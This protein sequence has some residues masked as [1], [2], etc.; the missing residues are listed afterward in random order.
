M[1]ENL[2]YREY[3]TSKAWQ[4]K[5]AWYWAKVGK[6]ACQI[7]GNRQG[8]HVHHM[9]YDH[10][11]NEWFTDL[12]GVCYACHDGIHELHRKT[13]G[14][15]YVATMIYRNLNKGRRFH[16]PKSKRHKKGKRL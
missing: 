15:L 9:R 12:L 2:K 4:R 7:C 3:I 8:L 13:G 16:K 10:L 5:K 6:R 14:S 1:K 11:G